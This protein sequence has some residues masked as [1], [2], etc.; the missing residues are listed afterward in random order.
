MK[1]GWPKQHGRGKQTSGKLGKGVT[2]CAV[3]V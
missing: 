1:E 2:L 3:R